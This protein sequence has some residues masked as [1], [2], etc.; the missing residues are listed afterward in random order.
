ME[1]YD[2]TTEIIDMMNS[3][4]SIEIVE[5]Y[6][7]KNKKYLNYFLLILYSGH[8][9]KYD[10]MLYKKAV[11]HSNINVLQTCRSTDNYSELDTLSYKHLVIH[12]CPIYQ[13]LCRKRML[14]PIDLLRVLK[15]FL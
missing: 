8:Y 13:L 12:N 2:I 7:T 6:V 1:I 5:D 15:Q 4:T 11:E 10:V 3:K 9:K 14:L